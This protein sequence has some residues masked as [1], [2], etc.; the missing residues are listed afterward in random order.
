MALYFAYGSN[1]DQDQ[2]KDRCPNSNEV[3][4]GLI[5]NYRIDFSRKSIRRNCGVADILE[6]K[7][8]NTWGVIY[9]VSDEDFM[10]LDQFEGYPKY[11][12]KKL[13]KCYQFVDPN[14]FG[15]IPDNMSIQEYYEELYVNPFNFKEIETFV[16]EVIEKSS[17]TIQPSIEYLHLLQGAAEEHFFPMEYQEILNAF[18]AELRNQLNSQALDLF[19]EI[20]ELI[21][22]PN[23]AQKIESTQE[24][25]GADLVITGSEDRKKQ[26]NENYPLD[27]VVLTPYWKELSWLVSHIYNSESTKWLFNSYNKY[28]YFK[29]FGEAAIE[30]QNNN[31]NDTDHIGICRAGIANAYSLLT[32]GGILFVD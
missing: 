27:L 17:S 32:E 6:S 26:L 11:Y 12:T 23:F 2:M 3:G 21:A 31:P 5:P 8:D 22:M 28:I 13:I 25:G 4:T 1:M 29:E 24:F 7:G 16:Y 10:S 15:S 30:Y 9:D 18:G 19:L 20:S 14:P